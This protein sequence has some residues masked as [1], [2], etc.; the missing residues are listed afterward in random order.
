MICLFPA[1]LFVTGMAGDTPHGTPY[2]SFLTCW[3]VAAQ[4]EEQTSNS[5]R[6]VL[7]RPD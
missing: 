2:C 6:C 5:A 7:K 3:T 4:I 1:L